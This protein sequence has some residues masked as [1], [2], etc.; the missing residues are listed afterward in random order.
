MNM[1]K[2][3]EKIINDYG[4]VLQSEDTSVYAK[5]ISRLHYSKDQIK[6]ALLA[7]LAELDLEEIDFRETLIH[8]YV[9]LAQFVPDEQAEIAARGQKAIT[10]GDMNHPD[11]GDADE[12]VRIIND[13]KLDMEALSQEVSSLLHQQNT[14][15]NA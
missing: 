3:A 8:G 1:L 12:A 2:L 13:I 6:N 9:H 15:G 4:Q 10:S 14:Q 5:P 11:M 7:A